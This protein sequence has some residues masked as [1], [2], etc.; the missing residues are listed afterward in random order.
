MSYRA[1][2]VMIRHT[3]DPSDIADIDR[4]KRCCRA[5]QTAL[6]GLSAYL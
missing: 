6:E 4:L 2:L 3:F 5:S 1:T